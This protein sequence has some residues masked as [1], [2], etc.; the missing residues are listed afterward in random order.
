LINRDMRRLPGFKELLRNLGL[1]RYWRETGNWND[2]CR[3]VSDDDF[4][5]S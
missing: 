5:C 2:F 3:P 1:V 4:E